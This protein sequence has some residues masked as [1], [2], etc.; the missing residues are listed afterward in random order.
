M[1][2]TADRLSAAWLEVCER[3][4]EVSPAKGWSAENGDAR[5]LV[6]NTA[7]ASL[8][9]AFS[10]SVEPDLTSLDEM[11]TE[12]GGSGVPWSIIVRGDASE[13]VVALAARHGLGHR[14]EMPLMAC[15]AEDAVLR[16][17]AR[18]AIHPVCSAGSALY[19]DVLTAGFE[20]PE[21]AFGALMGGGVL[22]TPGFTGYLAEEDGRSV[23]TGLG[24]EGDGAI[25]VFNIA[26]VPSARSRG[27]GRAMTA[28]VMADGFAAG[29]RT[30][31]LHASAAGRPLYESMGFRLVETWTIFT[32][33]G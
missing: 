15:S 4:C 31:Y 10:T 33:L 3:L 14:G 19:T 27:L 12:V 24:T 30:A 20:V 16:T 5:G 2:R 21:G 23:A 32:E 25:G 18:N 7:V 11:A 8:N 1:S 22:D 17:N 26:V 6:S 9:A 13:A 29:A 28:R